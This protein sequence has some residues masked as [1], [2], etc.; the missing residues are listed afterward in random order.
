M[1]LNDEL[2]PTGDVI[3]IDIIP[4]KIDKLNIGNHRIQD[5]YIEKYFS[6]HEKGNLSLKATSIDLP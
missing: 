6:E 4:E 3:A 2:L 5:K 1:S